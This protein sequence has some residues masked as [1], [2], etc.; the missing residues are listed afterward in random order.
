[1]WYLRNRY[2]KE[3]S[4]EVSF[5]VPSANFGC[6]GALEETPFCNDS[7]KSFGIFAK[8]TVN[9]VSVLWIRIG[10]NADLDP[11]PAFYL[12]ADKDP[13]PGSQTNAHTGGSGSDF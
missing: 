10:S 2:L 11:D 6:N 3:N 13:D 1:V 12:I 9:F 7:G 5:V 4:E 8:I